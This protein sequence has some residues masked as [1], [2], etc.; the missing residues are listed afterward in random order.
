MS[1]DEKIRKLVLQLSGVFYEIK[2]DF[3][4]KLSST[5]KN[6]EDFSDLSV[7]LKREQ[8]FFKISESIL[9]ELTSVLLKECI[10]IVTRYVEVL[11]N[12]LE[13][14]VNDFKTRLEEEKKT[15]KKLLDEKNMLIKKIFVKEPK[16]KILA[17]VEEYGE[18]DL[19]NLKAKSKI[20]KEKL[21]SL[22]RNLRRERYIQIF[23]EANGLKIVFKNAPWH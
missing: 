11:N 13:L 4:K 17:L 21:M 5:F 15:L 20:P 14:A 22:L 8:G 9:E 7:E 18:S 12:N 10:K 19:K 2:E 23:K 3:M 6:E 16:F 1:S